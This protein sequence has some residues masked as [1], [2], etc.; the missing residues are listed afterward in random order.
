M[1][2]PDILGFCVPLQ[3]ATANCVRM[4]G[5]G[6]LCVQVDVRTGDIA[7]ISEAALAQLNAAL[8]PFQPIFNI[9]DTVKMVV[10]CLT[11]IPKAITSFDP[12]E[13][14][15]C[16]PG[17]VQQL[18]KLLAMIPQLSIPIMVSDIID[19]L[20][21]IL[22]GIRQDIGAMLRQLERIAAAATRAAAVGNVQLQVAVTCATENIDVQMANLNESLAPL[23]R[24]LGLIN[25]F[26]KLL[27]L[28]CLPTLSDLEA[29]DAAL[30]A[31]DLIIEAL[32]RIRTLFPNIELPAIPTTGDDGKC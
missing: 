13:L 4:P 27:G 15:N 6:M 29:S 21:S 14:L 17:L 9:I 25:A 3:P 12:T 26:L 10:D 1:E 31:I 18:N 24:L 19:L 22:L 5:G 16:I 30:D 28:P 11:A 32:Q 8:M 2:L 23:N 20:I 7:K